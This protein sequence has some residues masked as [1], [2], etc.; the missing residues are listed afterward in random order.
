MDLTQLIHRHPLLLADLRGLGLSQPRLQ[1]LAERLSAQLGA[2]NGCAGGNLSQVLAR[3]DRAAFLVAVDVHEVASEAGISP[4][5]AR[6]SVCTIAPW[7]ERF[8]HTQS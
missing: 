8:R 6:A 1:A 5:L 7:V 2:R 3:L 4:A